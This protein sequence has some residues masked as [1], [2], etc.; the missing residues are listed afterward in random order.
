VHGERKNNH[1]YIYLK[2]QTPAY[3]FEPPHIRGLSAWLLSHAYAC[4]IFTRFQKGGRKGGYQI[5]A[6]NELPEPN[7]IAVSIIYK[8]GFAIASA[9]KITPSQH[10]W[11]SQL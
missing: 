7:I 10:F 2:Q 6:V 5:P 8:V 1:P 11:A 3:G 4:I 9:G